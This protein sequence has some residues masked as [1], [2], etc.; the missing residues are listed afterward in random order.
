MTMVMT[1]TTTM[2]HDDDDDDD[3]RFITCFL[4]FVS[5]SLDGK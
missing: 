2:T 1:M 5:D 4:C 3:V